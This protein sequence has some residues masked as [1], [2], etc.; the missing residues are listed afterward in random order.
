[1]NLIFLQLEQIKA[2]YFFTFCAFVLCILK[3]TLTVCKNSIEKT[4]SIN[5][6][7]SY[8]LAIWKHTLFFEVL[9]CLFQQ[10][11]KISR[12]KSKYLKNN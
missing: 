6:L 1:M 11:I 7:N 2:I 8:Q 10:T 3:H 4:H 9:V 5:K 12:F